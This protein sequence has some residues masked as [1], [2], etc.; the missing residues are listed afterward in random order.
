MLCVYVCVWLFIVPML[1]GYIDVNGTLDL[2]RFEK[3]LK[4]IEVTYISSSSLLYVLKYLLVSLVKQF[5]LDNFAYKIGG[6]RWFKGKKQQPTVD[7]VEVFHKQK[8][9]SSKEIEQSSEDGGQALF[10]F[11][12]LDDSVVEDT[13]S[14]DKLKASYSSSCSG[15][16]SCGGSG[17]S[18]V[19]VFQ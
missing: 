9:V 11:G 6:Q 16:G 4:A 13:K 2:G 5:D 1:L 17:S 14:I 10:L 7:N 8:S 12:G 19:I 15:S 18:S 3:Y